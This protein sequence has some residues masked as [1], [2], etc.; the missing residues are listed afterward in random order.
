MMNL[1]SVRKSKR[2]VKESLRPWKWLRGKKVCLYGKKSGS[3]IVTSIVN[4]V[5]L[6]LL[7]TQLACKYIIYDACVCALLLLS[8][9][10]FPRARVYVCVGAQ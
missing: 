4:H 3:N 2:V 1:T 7:D 6:L 5:R 8:R 10:P 9:S